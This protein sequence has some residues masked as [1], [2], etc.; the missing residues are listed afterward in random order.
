[1]GDFVK[2]FARPDTGI[3]TVEG[4]VSGSRAA[5][6]EKE[7]QK[8]QEAFEAKKA[9]MEED[10]KRG[11]KRIDDKF[12]QTTENATAVD[13]VGLVTADE[14]KR[15]M[16]E[17]NKRKESADLEAEEAEREKEDLK[18][19]KQKKKKKKK[20]LSLSFAA[21]DEDEDGAGSPSPVKKKSKKN[22]EV[23]TS[24]LPDK[25]REAEQKKEERRLK[26]EYIAKQEAI[27]EEKLKI[28][29]SYWDGS[30]HR[31]EITVKKGHT[32]LEFLE[33]VRLDL[34][35]QFR[36]VAAGVAEDLMYVKEDIMLPCDITFYDLITTKARGKSGPLFSFDVHDDIRIGAV[37][38]RVEKDESHPGKIVDRKWYDRNK[39]IFPASRWE[40][41]DPAKEFTKF[42]IKG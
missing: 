24:F 36:E 19:K 5:G 13:V 33:L 22:P 31:K 27:K 10:S 35:S 34:S 42:T 16:E 1:M 32:I 18:K 23:E 40:Q 38:S 26:Q 12:Q 6:L 30:G 41:Y 37:D 3:R 17:K 28:T 11:A 4:Q 29:Y 25:D 14:W 8:S 20:I 15:R 7:R 21:D 39:H 2:K 9:K